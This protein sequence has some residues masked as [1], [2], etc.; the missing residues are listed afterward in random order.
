MTYA[1]RFK[2]TPEQLAEVRALRE[3]LKL[4]KPREFAERLNPGQPNPEWA[5][6]FEFTDVNQATFFGLAVA[7]RVTRLD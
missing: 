4:K 6:T 7:P 2:A 5:Y 3:T 1:V